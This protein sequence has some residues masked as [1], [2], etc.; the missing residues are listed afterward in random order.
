[1]SI[2]PAI[3]KESVRSEKN[4]YG[5]ALKRFFKHKLAVCGL[6]FLSIAIFMAIFAPI[7]APHDPEKIYWDAIRMPP[8]AQFWFGTDEIG[9]DIFSRLIYGTRVSFS[10]VFGSIAIALSVGSMI[11]LI[12]GFMRGWIDVVIMRVVDAMLAF[13]TLILALGIIAVLGPSLFNA[14]LAIAITN[15]PDFARLVRGQVLL[16]R[17]QDF[18]QAARA[19]GAHNVRIMAFHLWPSVV[20]NVIVYASLRTSV[21]LLTESSLAF[22][23]LGVPPP[24]ATWG[25]MLATSLSY[26]SYWWIGV[27]PGLAILFAV[28]AFNFIGDGMRDAL[29]S[30]SE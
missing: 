14:M 2:T 23:G 18:I 10:I 8:S 9:R 26:I 6:I 28:L 3:E 5:K 24:T 1:M 22:L 29:D 30:R 11:G 16:V 20:G 25:Q 27:F 21:A 4:L 7:V 15:V 12:S 19:M 17:E 13:P